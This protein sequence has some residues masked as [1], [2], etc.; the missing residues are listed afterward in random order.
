MKQMPNIRW[1]KWECS[2]DCKSSA[3]KTHTNHEAPYIG[4]PILHNAHKAPKIPCSQTYD[5]RVDALVDT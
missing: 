5:I 1:S 4:S 2:Q 3:H